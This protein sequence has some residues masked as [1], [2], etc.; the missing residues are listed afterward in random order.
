MAK[1]RAKSLSALLKAAL[2]TGFSEIDPELE[3]LKV[4]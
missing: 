3:P 2:S 1:H 4:P